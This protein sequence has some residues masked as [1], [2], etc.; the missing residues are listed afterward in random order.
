VTNPDS[1]PDTAAACTTT[2]C[3]KCKRATD[4]PAHKFGCD[5]KC[6]WAAHRPDVPVLG[7]SDDDA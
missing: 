2:Y 3:Q 1:I 6:N 5:C 4:D 7:G